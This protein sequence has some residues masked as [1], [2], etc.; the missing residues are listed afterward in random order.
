M[1]AASV[2]PATSISVHTSVTAS[3]SP[4]PTSQPRSLPTAHSPTGLQSGGIRDLM[5]AVCWG[6]WM[7]L[8]RCEPTRFIHVVTSPSAINRRATDAVQLGVILQR[9]EVVDRSLI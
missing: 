5:Y 3:L 4:T 9:D 8:S 7:L 2:T 6:L 1:T